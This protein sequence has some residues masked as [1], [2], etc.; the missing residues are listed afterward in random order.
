LKQKTTFSLKLFCFF[1][2]NKLLCS[3]R[4]R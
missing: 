1:G 3:I 2:K 4:Y